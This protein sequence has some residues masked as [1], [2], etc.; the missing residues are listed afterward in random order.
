MPESQRVRLDAAAEGGYVVGGL[1]A[2]PS[3]KV[4]GHDLTRLAG[5]DRWQT[6]RLL[7]GNQAR[8]LAGDDSS[9]ADASAGAE[10]PTTDCTGDVPIVAA[11]DAA[12]Q[13]DLYSAV[14]LTGVFGTDCI[15]L[16]GARDE[17]MPTEQQ[18]RLNAA[19]GG[20]YIVGGRAAMP[21]TKVSGRDMTRLA[22]TDRWHTAQLVGNQARITVVGEAA[23]SSDYERVRALQVPIV[24]GNSRAF[25]RQ[26]DR[27]MAF[28][29]M[30]FLRPHFFQGSTVEAVTDT[31]QQP[32]HDAK[33][34][35]EGARQ[36]VEAWLRSGSCE[37]LS[38]QADLTTMFIEGDESPLGF[39][40]WR[41]VAEAIETGWADERLADALSSSLAE[42]ARHPS[43]GTRRRD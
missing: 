34:S 9:E 1:A 39:E 33:A 22:G 43:A 4:T 23:S 41:L 27:A 36:V 42:D 2:V 10:D 26:P 14:T 20:G 8:S 12:A 35:E 31:T 40:V 32:R 7:V 37:P 19:A 18:V 28:G 15:V 11:S 5:T 29:E 38:L 24:T 17:P 13:S 21:D 16:A 3:A 30:N 6:A 25:L